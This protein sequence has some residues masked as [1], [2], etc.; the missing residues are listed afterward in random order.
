MNSSNFNRTVFSKDY[1]SFM[2]YMSL[3]TVHMFNWE[4]TLGFILLLS[5]LNSTLSEVVLLF[6]ASI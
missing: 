2:S 6:Y 5:T 4:F 3:L 1:H